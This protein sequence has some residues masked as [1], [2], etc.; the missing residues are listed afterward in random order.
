MPG[1]GDFAVNSYLDAARYSINAGLRAM[2][3][4]LKQFLLR[5]GVY[6]R[7]KW[8][9]FFGVYR[10]LFQREHV[11]AAAREKAFYASFL[12]S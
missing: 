6:E 1:S 11:A 9:P 8:S 7:L 10:R 12:S 4:A 2:K 3:Q 5:I